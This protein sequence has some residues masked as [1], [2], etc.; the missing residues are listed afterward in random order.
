MSIKNNKAHV[1]LSVGFVAALAGI[2]LSTHMNV[3]LPAATNSLIDGSLQSFYEAD[4]D[5]M[6]PLNIYAV[7]ALSTLK[8]ALFS[9]AAEGAVVGRD[10]WIYTA[11]EFEVGPNFDENLVSAA[12]EIARVYSFMAA[13]GVALVPMIV[14]DK[15]DVYPEFLSI[16]RSGLVETRREK[17][18]ALLAA[19]NITALDA[20]PSLMTQKDTVASFLKDDTHWSPVGSRAVAQMLGSA[21]TSIDVELTPATVTTVRGPVQSFDGDLL[22]YVPTGGFRDAFGP[23]QLSIDTFTTTVESSGGLF[24]DP[25]VDV[26]LVGTSFSA[27][28]EWNFLGFV[29]DALD[30]DVMN[31]AKEGQGPFAP[32]HDF[33]ASETFQNTPPKLVIWEIP[34]RYTSKEMI[35]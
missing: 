3:D 31:F 8:F 18:L 34:A 13:N 6:N 23:A 32:M 28:P 16:Q 27:K 35:R 19:R 33:L 20:T 30:A 12:D 21:L 25:S 26:A 9:Q 1:Y 15:A 22:Q 14:P 24:G 4:F 5:K 10:G 29:Q 2:G 11:E 17:L 7:T